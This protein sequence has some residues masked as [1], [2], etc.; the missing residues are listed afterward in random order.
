MNAGAFDR[1]AVGALSVQ[2]AIVA[3]EGDGANISK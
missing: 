3:G 2:P 1:F